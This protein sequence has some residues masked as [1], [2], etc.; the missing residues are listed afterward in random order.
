[1]WSWMFAQQKPDVEVIAPIEDSL[2]SSG[3]PVALSLTAKDKKGVEIPTA[4]IVWTSSL[5][6]QL[7]IG[8]SLTAQNLSI[9]VHTITAV[10]N[11]AIHHQTIR[12]A[13]TISIIRG[14]AY[15]AQFDFGSPDFTSPGWNNVDHPS[16][17]Y[18]ANALDTSGT[19]TGVRTKIIAPF[20]GIQVGGELASDIF[21]ENVQRDTLW[22]QNGSNPARLEISGL[23]PVQNYELT[24]FASRTANNNRVGIYTANGKSVSLNASN[25]TNESVTL[26]NLTPS[27]DGKIILSVEC[28]ADSTY[29]YL[30]A[31]VLRT[32]GSPAEL[33]KQTYFNAAELLDLEIA[34]DLADPDEDGF[35]NL[36]EYA[37]SMD[38]RT[39]DGAGMA[40]AVSTTDTT[41][42]LVF[43]R[44]ASRIDL[45]YEVLST[46]NLTAWTVIARSSRGNPFIKVGEGNHE[47]FEASTTPIQIRINDPT[48]NGEKFYRLKIS[49]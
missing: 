38:P 32:S 49:R 19:A 3:D 36:L 5:D 28:H 39:S 10:V 41:P 14:G 21:P 33:W 22:I 9:G 46:D 44:D 2:Y 17:G 45:T 18:I 37:F 1:M 15:E 6:G 42:A 20:A 16:A 43:V 8:A 40:P 26:N 31:L 48:S 11:D 27:F 34:G 4:G 47:I 35:S 24:L 7:G 25:N 23:S 29:A 30:G 12:T 13:R